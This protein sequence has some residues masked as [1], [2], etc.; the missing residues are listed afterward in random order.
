[1][2]S[3]LAPYAPLVARGMLGVGFLY[4]GLPKWSPGGHQG[5]GG[6]L[7]DIGIP[8]PGVM[9]W[10]VSVVEVGGALAML[11]GAVVGLAG[12]LLLIEMLVAMFAVHFANGFNF[13]HITG[14][15]QAG[16]LFG[17]PGYEVNLLY[18]ALILVVL[19][20]GPGRW[21]VDEWRRVRPAAD[22]R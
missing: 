13:I 19:L 1:M 11:A 6:L 16:P 7:R 22:P 5:L 17:M 10:V 2:R 4:H 14:M 20:G 18:I 15:G 3:S 8:L 21:S 9:S 12:V